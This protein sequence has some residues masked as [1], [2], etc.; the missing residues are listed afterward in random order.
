MNVPPITHPLTVYHL[1]RV[2]WAART[3]NRHHCQLSLRMEMSKQHLYCTPHIAVIT[4]IDVLLTFCRSGVS[5]KMG[6]ERWE[7]PWSARM[8]EFMTWRIPLCG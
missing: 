1:Y 7:R 4:L 5:E 2:I 8:D 6:E 3:A